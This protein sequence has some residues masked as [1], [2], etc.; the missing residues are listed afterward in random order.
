MRDIHEEL[1]YWYL[2]PRFTTKYTN[3]WSRDLQ[4]NILILDPGIYNKI[5]WFK[6][7]YC[8]F[9]RKNVVSKH[10]L[11]ILM[12][13][14]VLSLICIYIPIISISYML[15]KITNKEL[16]LFSNGVPLFVP[17]LTLIKQPLFSMHFTVRSDFNL[18]SK[19]LK[20][21]FLNKGVSK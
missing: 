2:I 19:R 7:T 8:I 18:Y 12:F 15:I 9:A 5:Y 11:N 14:K 21:L 13:I 17:I 1:I 10:I 20:R 16:F 3:T 6:V 4:H